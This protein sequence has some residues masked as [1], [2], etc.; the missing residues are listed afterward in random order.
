M[1]PIIIFCGLRNNNIP[2]C[3][4]WLLMEFSVLLRREREC[5]ESRQQTRC[6]KCL[7]YPLQRRGMRKVCKS[8]KYHW[9]IFHLFGKVRMAGKVSRLIGI[10]QK[11]CQIFN[12]CQ[13]GFR[14]LK[15][16]DGVQCT[17]QII[18]SYLS[19]IN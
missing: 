11:T 9:F 7:H 2:L 16:E 15:L 6:C 4:I 12:K 17:N 5:R 10:S 13:K 8:S 14:G 3:N 19:N 1:F 18:S